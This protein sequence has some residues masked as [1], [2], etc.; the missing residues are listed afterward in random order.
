MIKILLPLMLVTITLSAKEASINK[1]GYPRIKKKKINKYNLII[2]KILVGN[3]NAIF[4][5]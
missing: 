1:I 4:P 3:F 5:K 2:L